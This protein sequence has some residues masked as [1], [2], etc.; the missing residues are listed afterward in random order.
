MIPAGEETKPL[1]TASLALS[2]RWSRLP[3]L[4]SP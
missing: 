4:S 2:W 1:M 3:A